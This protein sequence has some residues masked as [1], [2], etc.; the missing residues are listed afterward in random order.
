ML[1]AVVVSWSLHDSAVTWKHG[2]GNREIDGLI[3]LDPNVQQQAL[4]SDLDDSR[5]TVISC[6]L[7]SGI[8][9]ILVPPRQRARSTSKILAY[10]AKHDNKQ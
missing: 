9:A 5:S 3:R 1:E 8:S 2:A 4:V 7:G 6:R 10:P